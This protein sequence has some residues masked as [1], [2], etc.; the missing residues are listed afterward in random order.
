MVPANVRPG[1]WKES[2]ERKNIR[3]PPA[4]LSL[5]NVNRSLPLQHT[6]I[7]H[8]ITFTYNPGSFETAASALELRKS[9]TLVSYNS[10]TLPDISPSGFQS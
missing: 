1:R 7:N 10:L 8:C 3:H 4:L 9:T 2:K 5:E 6:K